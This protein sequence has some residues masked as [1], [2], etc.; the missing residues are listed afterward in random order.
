[1]MNNPDQQAQAVDNRAAN[2]VAAD[3]FFNMGLLK[4][5]PNQ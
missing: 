1:M 2:Q 3:A 4:V 5:A